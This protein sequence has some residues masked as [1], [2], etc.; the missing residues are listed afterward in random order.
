MFLGREI[1]YVL[2]GI[3]LRHNICHTLGG[4]AKDLALQLELNISKILFRRFLSSKH[5]QT[6]PIEIYFL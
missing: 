5:Y 1:W 4:E 3:A 6:K 2:R